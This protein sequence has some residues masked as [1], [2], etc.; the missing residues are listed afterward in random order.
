MQSNEFIENSSLLITSNNYD[1]VLP[2]NENAIH[3][4]QTVLASAESLARLPP[5]IIQIWQKYEQGALPSTTEEEVQYL[6]SC[7][8]QNDLNSIQNTNHGRFCEF[9]TDPSASDAGF[10]PSELQKR[11]RVDSDF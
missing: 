2:T 11:R 1:N 6:L 4:G 7:W 8:F 10:L 9:S 3:Y 5:E